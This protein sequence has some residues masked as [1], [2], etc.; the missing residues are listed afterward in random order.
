MFG[1]NS[2]K[3]KDLNSLPAP[4]EW[5]TKADKTRMECI[6]KARAIKRMLAALVERANNP[7]TLRELYAISNKATE[8]EVALIEARAKPIE[9]SLEFTKEKGE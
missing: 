8:I 1:E 3:E 6:S 4:R 9:L 7:D 2:G 5:P